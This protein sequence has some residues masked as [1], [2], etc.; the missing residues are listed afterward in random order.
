MAKID[1]SKVEVTNL[2]GKPIKDANLHK[3][4]AN[5]IYSFTKNLDLVSKALEMNSGKPVDLT[6]SEIEEVKRL[7]KDEKLG[8]AAF[9]QAAILAELDK[10]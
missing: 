5:G 10:A 8:L 2:E 4:V 3:L 6:A 9:V 1:L 7:V